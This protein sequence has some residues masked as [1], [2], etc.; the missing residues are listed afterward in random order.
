ME[1]DTG[2]L[3]FDTMACGVPQ[4]SLLSPRLFNIYMKLLGE[5]IQSFG[6]QCY[7]YANDTSLPSKSKK[8]VT[9][10]DQCLMSVIEWMRVN[11]LKPIP[12]KTDMFLVSRRQIRKKGCSLCWMIFLSL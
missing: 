10:L 8:A 1:G 11:K 4:D 7:Q 12:D 9:A 3:L 5:F 2:G 6:V